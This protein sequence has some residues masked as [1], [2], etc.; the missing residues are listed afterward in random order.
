MVSNKIYNLSEQF[1]KF[2]LVAYREHVW[3]SLAHQDAELDK[4]ICWILSN[5]VI[6]AKEET[7]NLL[8]DNEFIIAK[9]VN[10]ASSQLSQPLARE[11]CYVLA[12]ILTLSTFDIVQKA[13]FDK[14]FLAI[15]IQVMNAENC[16]PRVI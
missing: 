10:C 11:G 4:E 1:V 9:L 14:G 3:K 7:V 16:S 5:V 13:V 15:L 6:C 12:N 2:E 8:L